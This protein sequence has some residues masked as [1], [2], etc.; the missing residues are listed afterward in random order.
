M[1][2]EAKPSSCDAAALSNKVHD[3]AA[4]RFAAGVARG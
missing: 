3:G 2:S 1:A 4:K